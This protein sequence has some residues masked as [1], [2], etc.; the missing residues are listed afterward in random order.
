MS[1]VLDYSNW[2]KL[3]EQ[4]ENNEKNLKFIEADDEN[5]THYNSNEIVYRIESDGKNKYIKLTKAFKNKNDIISLIVNENPNEITLSY[6]GKLIN[7]KNVL[8]PLST[9]LS[10]IESDEKIGFYNLG[11]SFGKFISELEQK[12]KEI[13][14][15]SFYNAIIMIKNAAKTGNINS[16]IQNKF[17]LITIG[18]RSDDRTKN[19]QNFLKGLKTSIV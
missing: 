14:P 16:I 2:K 8:E 10:Y 15:E 19:V 17:E 4:L 1:Y 3:N 7:Y 18:G 6:Y 5:R 9:F 12:Q 11:I 13:I